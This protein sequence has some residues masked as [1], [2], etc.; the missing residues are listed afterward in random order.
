MKIISGIYKIENIVNHKIYIGYSA[1]IY[2]R[3]QDHKYCLNNNK[4][5]NKHLQ[6]S[7]NRHGSNNFKFLIVEEC[8]SNTD[9]LCEREIYWCKTLNANDNK[10]GYNK[11]NPG[12]KG[13]NL[14]PEERKQSSKKRSETWW[15]K[16]E[17][18]RLDIIKK[19]SDSHKG[20][21]PSNKSFAFTYENFSA[22]L[23]MYQIEKLSTIDIGNIF[24]VRYTVIT[25]LFKQMGVHIRSNSEGHSGSTKEARLN[26]KTYVENTK[27][28]QK[29]FN[30]DFHPDG[31]SKK[32]LGVK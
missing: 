13:P 14:T 28:Q 8:E 10:Y 19:F 16:P 23:D 30:I 6:S 31:F 3:W 26:N 4:H 18:E 27:K 11:A 1:D 5:C 17:E 21:T 2:R 7:W 29:N 22:M 9:V 20:K 15:S 24:N 25:N 32:G 12:S